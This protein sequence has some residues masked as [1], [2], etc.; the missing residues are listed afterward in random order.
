MQKII[1]IL[2]SSWLIGTATYAGDTNFVST[3]D[4]L[5]Q[6]ENASNVLSYVD[7]YLST[8]RNAEALFARGIV[9]A[10]LQSWGRGATNYLFQ[11][12]TN[13]TENMSYTSE[14]KV[15]LSNDIARIQDIFSGLVQDTGE[16]ENSTP[17]WD[18]NV[19]AVIF[20]E[21][22]G[23]APFLHILNEIAAPQ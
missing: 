12:I 15:K 13:V 22:G 4:S 9:A 10:G 19:H 16:P 5:W 11:A 3:F 1:V 20:M 21:S 17:S 8:N 18:T 6:S 2:V 7:S 23:E 14:Q